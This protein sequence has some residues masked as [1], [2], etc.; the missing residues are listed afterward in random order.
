MVKMPKIC[1]D[2]GH[3]GIQPGAVNGSIMEKDL[4]LKISLK[5]GEKLKKDGVEVVYTRINDNVEWSQEPAKDLGKRCEI[6]N[7]SGVDYFIS[8]HLNSS[9]NKNANGIETYCLARGGKGEKLAV[10][11]QR[12]LIKAVGAVNRGVKTANYY[13]L[14]NTHAPAVL[15]ETGFIS[16]QNDLKKLLD[17]S[18]QDILASAIERGILNCFNMPLEKSPSEYFVYGVKKYGPYL[19]ETYARNKCETLLK[20]GYAEIYYVKPD[21]SKVSV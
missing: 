11:I 4:A 7:S 6:S 5:V 21:G 1:I 19:Y 2:P 15:I 17:E 14:K 3:G 13:V 10:E 16:N 20:E 9:L 18:Y 8:I 12:E